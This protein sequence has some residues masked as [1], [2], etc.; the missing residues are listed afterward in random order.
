MGVYRQKQD[1]FIG[2][3]FT[4]AK[5]AFPDMAAFFT[6][7]KNNAEVSVN[8]GAATAGQVQLADD[9]AKG[10]GIAIRVIQD[11]FFHKHRRNYS[12]QT[13][14]WE[15]NMLFPFVF[16]WRMSSISEYSGIPGER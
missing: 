6:D 4:K 15:C 2:Q 8:T 10:F 9:M 11:S 7:N 12:P 1:R 14:S 5:I 13:S 3:V 16:L